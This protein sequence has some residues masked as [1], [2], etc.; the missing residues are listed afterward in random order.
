MP[1]RD[2]EGPT[3]GAMAGDSKEEGNGKSYIAEF[4]SLFSAMFDWGQKCF[5]FTF[6]LWRG[7]KSVELQAGKNQKLKY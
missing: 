6:C 4:K 7:Q 1:Q 5:K 2:T 3:G